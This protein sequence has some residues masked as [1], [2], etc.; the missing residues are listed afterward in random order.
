[1][2]QRDTNPTDYLSARLRW[3]HHIKDVAQE[4]GLTSDEVEA[5]VAQLFQDGRMDAVE[6]HANRLV[7][8]NVQGK[9]VTD[10]H[11]YFCGR[12]RQVVQELEEIL[13]KRCE[14][15]TETDLES[16]TYLNLANLGITE[17]LEGDFRGLKNLE[18][19]HLSDNSLK[20]VPDRIFSHTPK[21]EYLSL[22]YNKIESLSGNSLVG[23]VN[24]QKLYL[25]NNVIS[26]I[27]TNLFQD[28]IELYEIDLSNNKLTE[29]QLSVFNANHNLASLHIAGNPYIGVPENFVAPRL[30][31][32]IFDLFN[33]KNIP[34]KNFR[35][36]ILELEDRGVIVFY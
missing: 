30:F 16:V 34:L 21:L 17:L 11:E 31:G 14:E 32:S 9:S 2:F 23:L 8:Q 18:V 6:Q 36:S 24:L 25:D 13:K 28:L 29:L 35:K 3:K 1:L 10:R 5:Q 27:P 33:A 20:T 4:M 15:F 22:D 12:T 19:I 7:N 26:N